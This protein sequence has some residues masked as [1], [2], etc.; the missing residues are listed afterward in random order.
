MTMRNCCLKMR[1]FCNFSTIPT[2]CAVSD[3]HQPVQL[4]L[5]DISGFVSLIY[6]FDIF[7]LFNTSLV[8]NQKC[9]SHIYR[10]VL[11][12]TSYTLWLGDYCSKKI[13]MCLNI[14]SAVAYIHL[15]KYAYRLKKKRKLITCRIFSFCSCYCTFMY[16]RMW[17]GMG[18]WDGSWYIS[19]LLH[20]NFTS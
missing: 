2:S 15:Y 6:F 10:I 7:Q 19:F 13:E 1:T 14:A 12:Y 5:E 8:I 16:V 11:S 20:Q 9:F 17:V 4:V 18:I 3:T